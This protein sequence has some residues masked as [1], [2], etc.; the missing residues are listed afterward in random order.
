MV[1]CLL[2][3]TAFVTALNG[4]SLSSC[5]DHSMPIN[6][7]SVVVGPPTTGKSQAM[8]ECAI[9]PL[10][11]VRDDNDLGNYL[12]ERCTASALIKCLSEQKK[13]VVVSP[14]IY[15][16]L[17]KMMKH[18]EENGSGEIQM[19]CELFSGE[20]TLYRF[21]T[22]KTREIPENV[23]FAIIGCTQV[24]FAARLVCRMDE[25]HGLLDRFMLWFPMCLRPSP[26]GTGEAKAFLSDI[27]LKSFTD[28]FIEM[29]L[30]FLG[31]QVFSFTEPAQEMMDSLQAEFI[32]QLNESIT[33][34][35]PAP[36]SKRIDLI[37]RL[38][39]SLHVF[40]HVIKL[41]VGGRK[42]RRPSKEVS[43]ETVKKT[44]LLMEYADS[45]KQIV[46]DV[47]RTMV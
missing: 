6:L 20:R 4:S 34:G 46:I 21:A 7:Y 22:G 33:E 41:L 40:T 39:V 37:Q 43:L 17:N 30:L 38:A 44:V 28:V 45:Q 16:V 27:P 12:V 29:Y 13:A 10:V 2:T 1:P 11:A 14:E 9:D 24:P 26:N 47:S 5:S 36:K 23:P 15:D 19:L 3:T 35:L 32:T 42:P 18:D 8:K 25:G 31:K